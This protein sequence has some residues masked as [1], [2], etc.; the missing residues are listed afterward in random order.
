MQKKKKNMMVCSVR[1]WQTSEEGD[2]L[3]QLGQL[4]M[5]INDYEYASQRHEM[6]IGPTE[7][8]GGSEN[9]KTISKF[10]N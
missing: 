4:T 8:Q 10:L 6:N 2:I 9:P 1:H 3:P 7:H 5:L